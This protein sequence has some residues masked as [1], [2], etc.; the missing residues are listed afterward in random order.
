[1]R[2][3]I[4]AAAACVVSLSA[5]ARA[6]VQV[7][8]SIIPVHSLISGVMEGVGKPHLLVPA[9]ASLHTFALRPSDARRLEQA[10]AVF[11]VGP[12]LE[13]FLDRPLKALARKAEVVALAG[14]DGVKQLPFRE[15]GPWDEHADGDEPGKHGEKSRSDTGHAQ[16]HGHDHGHAHHGTDGHIWLDP[17]N[18]IAMTRTIAKELGHVDPANKARYEANAAG[19]AARIEELDKELAA[20]LA[21]LKGERYIVFHDA[22][23]YFE[24]RYGLTPAG[25]ITVSPET[26]PGAKRITE[27]RTRVLKDRATCVFSEPQFEPRLVAS[28]VQGTQAKTAALD[29][30]GATVDPGPE[31][32]FDIMRKLARSLTGCLTGRK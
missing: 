14:A 16:E 9:G 6:E 19:I 28:L 17:K 31:A 5:P 15:G 20:E 1:M 12:T 26:S 3:I 29:P 30:E 18:A 4:L 8:A 10:Q 21:P 32:Y 22:Y 24:A 23:Q 13:T 7:V 2:P 25:S 11:W 27:I